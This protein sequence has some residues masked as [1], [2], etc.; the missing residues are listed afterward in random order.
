M[1]INFRGKA[2]YTF[3]TKTVA[4]EDDD[5]TDFLKDRVVC[6]QCKGSYSRMETNEISKKKQVA[7][8]YEVEFEAFQSEG[9]LTTMN[10]IIDD[11]YI[12]T[13]PVERKFEVK[14]GKEF[15]LAVILADDS[16]PVTLRGFLEKRHNTNRF[17]FKPR[18]Y[19]DSKNKTQKQ[20]F[21]IEFEM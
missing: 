20:N 6:F 10:F 11:V 2:L 15:D 19:V 14:N 21:K 8:R 1:T 9:S 16:K 7:K 18:S 13:N 5:E 4:V 12:T 3:K 17:F